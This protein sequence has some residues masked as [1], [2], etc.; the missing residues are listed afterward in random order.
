VPLIPPASPDKPRVLVVDDH[1][2]T[3]DT[4]RFILEKM[5]YPAKVAYATQS[6]LQVTRVFVPEIV[7]LDLVMAGGNGLE[8]ARQLRQLAE[9]KQAVL[10]C[11]SGYASAE[12]RRET[13]AAGCDYHLLKPVDWLEL[14]KIME[15]GRKP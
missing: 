14:L 3:A 4:T 11:I 6:A 9:T 10:I 13:R 15:K 2:D 7:L 5:G 1:H 12:D 8:L